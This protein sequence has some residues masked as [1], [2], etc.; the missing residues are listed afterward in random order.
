MR[1]TKSKVKWKFTFTE[2]SKMKIYYEKPSWCSLDNPKK[3]P[4]TDRVPHR[5]RNPQPTIYSFTLQGSLE[6]ISLIM[7]SFFSKRAGSL[8]R[9]KFSYGAERDLHS[10]K[11]LKRRPLPWGS[12]GWCSMK[13]PR[14]FSQTCPSL[15]APVPRLPLYPPLISELQRL[16]AWWIPDSL[17]PSYSPGS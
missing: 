3:E 2:Q 12:M 17:S 5:W 9:V 6:T 11:C 15:F 16:A 10:T 8:D 13:K 7:H 4:Q 14:A 1:C